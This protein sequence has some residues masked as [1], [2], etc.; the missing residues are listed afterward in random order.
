MEIRSIGNSAA[1]A[2]NVPER[3]AVNNSRTATPVA[4]ETSKQ[5]QD[6]P[7]TENPA[8]KPA[9]QASSLAQLNEAVSKIN[10]SFKSNMQ[11]IEFSLD[12]DNGQ[13]IVKVVDQDTKELIRQMPSEEALEIAK[14]LDQ[15]TGMLIKQTA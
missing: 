6:V 13:V 14:A 4:I 7:V 8:E 10:E 9:E 11:G 15:A 12:D 1:A 2:L 3:S 5:N